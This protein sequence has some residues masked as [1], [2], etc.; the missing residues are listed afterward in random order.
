M[1]DAGSRIDADDLLITNGAQQ[2]IELVFRTFVERGDAVIIEEP[3]YTGALT[4]LGSIGARVIGIAGGP[5]KAAFLVDELGFDAAIDYRNDDVAERLRALAPE[6]VDVF[7]D[8]VGGPILDA[9]LEL[10]A[11][12]RGFLILASERDDEALEFTAARNLEREGRRVL[13]AQ[14][15]SLDI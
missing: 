13:L 4:V 15:P 8:N 2:A 1:R 14:Q 7:Y 9:V 3:T 6:G 12:E 5:A 10:S 11:A